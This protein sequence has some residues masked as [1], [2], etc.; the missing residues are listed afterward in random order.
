MSAL[1]AT[2]HRLPTWLLTLAVVLGVAGARL[3]LISHYG[4]D[5][6]FHDQWAA[7]GFYRNWFD[8]NL[9]WRIFF[10]PH[11]EHRP[12][13]TRLLAM[14]GF[15]VNG[16]WDCRVQ[17]LVNLGIYLSAVALLCE[18][19]RRLL[20]PRTFLP[21]AG[22]ALLLFSQ[23]A[24]FE[25]AL[26]GFQSQFYLLLLLGAAHVLGSCR[27][28]MDL[29]WALAP[30]AGLLGLF[31]IAAGALSAA[32]V[33]LLS[34]SDLVRNGKSV[35]A[36]ATLGINSG[37]LL[38][39]WWSFPGGVAHST[40]AESLSQ[41]LAAAGHLL[42]WPAASLWGVVLF[43]PVGLFAWR[44]ARAANST[45][46]QR[47]LL[48]CGIWCVL[49][50][51][52]FAYGRGTAP[53]SIAVRYYDVLAVGVFVNAVAMAWLWSEAKNHR[54]LYGAALLGWI[55]IWGA[56]YVRLNRP[57]EVGRILGEWRDY[58]ARQQVVIR[59]F[60]ATDDEGTLSKDPL[61]SR[62]LPHFELAR[63]LLRDPRMRARLPPSLV[64]PLA[65][66]RDAVRARG[67]ETLESPGA[68]ASAS[69]G[70]TD[71][72]Y[73][74]QPLKRAGLAV[75]RFRVEGSPDDSSSSLWLE[76][77]NGERVHALGGDVALTPQGRTVNF[78]VGQGDVRVVARTTA[79]SGFAF[80]APIEVGIL[81]WFAP[82]I[83]SAW[84]AVLGG[85]GLCFVLG[86]VGVLRQP[87]NGD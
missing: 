74:S 2:L 45:A 50:I 58:F 78:L 81:S 14:A 40:R 10:Y 6:P 27:A 62:F 34:A 47:G 1:L 17:M 43:V 20:A 85:A 16:Q 39:G 86:A 31:T 32:A 44:I 87:R 75:L 49:M 33:W 53:G 8:G 79:G 55:L 12:A 41:F 5:Q 66:R 37:L 30:L 21:I 25:N 71:Q 4:S 69:D 70:L 11:N 63:D 51:A 59:E 26:W 38:L 83:L 46:P 76:R 24:N 15:W 73:A 9:E 28:R 54:P 84:P 29:P 19:A 65:M 3:W 80:S 64:P 82:K 18:L 60:L 7:E 22:I 23:P 52:A 56:G 13:L 61:V 77:A 42:A 67:F 48:A 36:V 68:R 57:A 72:L 35:R